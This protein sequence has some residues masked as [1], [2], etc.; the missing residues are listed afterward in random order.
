MLK[1]YSATIRYALVIID[2]LLIL[3]A[4]YVAYYLRTGPL[5]ELRWFTKELSPVGDYL[6][7]TFYLIVFTPIALYLV[8]AYQPFRREILFKAIGKIFFG[9]I[10]VIIF[11]GAMVFLRQE[12]VY[13]RSLLIIW[14][15]LY[16]F[17]LFAQRILIISFLRSIRR[18]GFNYRQI[19]IVGTGQAALEVISAIQSH[20]FWGIKIEG[21]ITEKGESRNNTFGLQRLGSL[22]NIDSIL[23]RHALDD[24]YFTLG[25]THESL[26]KIATACT[27]V[28]CSLYVVPWRGNSDHFRISAEQLGSIPLI[29]YRN[30]PKAHLQ[31]FI[32]RALDLLIASLAMII[33]PVIYVIAG[34]LIKLDSPGPVLYSSVRLAHNRRRFQCYKFRTMVNDAD[35]LIYLLKEV[36]DLIEKH[37]RVMIKLR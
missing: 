37:D 23:R 8:G 33:F 25:P 6:W 5:S 11:G 28:G 2:A 29:S 16:C 13:S 19:G 36:N 18:R 1:E 3:P 15:F 30:T 27:L 12:W 31:R 22:K 24:L 34:V 20:S 4:F 14:G 35:K 10:M 21:L 7:L 32:K 9:I 26:E 17:F